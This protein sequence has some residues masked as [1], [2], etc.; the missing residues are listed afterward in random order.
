MKRT[1]AR[2]ELLSSL[3]ETDAI[4]AVRALESQ[5]APDPVLPFVRACN[6][7]TLAKFRMMFEGM[8]YSPNVAIAGLL[9]VGELQR[10]YAAIERMKQ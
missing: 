10:A 7:E 5:A 4:A 6:P 1:P 3:A 9:L 2:D 8:A